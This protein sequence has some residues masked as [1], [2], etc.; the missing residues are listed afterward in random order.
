MLEGVEILST[1]IQ[2]IKAFNFNLFFGIVMVALITGIMCF[3]I[4]GEHEA[5]VLCL[6]SGIFI[7]SAVGTVNAR[8]IGEYPIYKVT[9]SEDVNFTEFNNKYEVLSQD[10]KIYTIKERDE[11]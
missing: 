9:V 1:C 8:T 7:G 11:N 3:I 4:M 10:G 6:I 2:Y 5:I